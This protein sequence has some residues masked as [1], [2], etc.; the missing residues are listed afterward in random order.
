LGAWDVGIIPTDKPGLPQQSYEFDAAVRRS[1]QMR[2]DYQQALV[3]LDTLRVNMRLSRDQVRPQLDLGAQFGFLGDSQTGLAVD[4]NGQ[5]IT[6]GQG[7][8]FGS[9]LE[10]LLSFDNFQWQVGFVLRQPLGN[11]A[12]LSRYRVDK[13]EIERALL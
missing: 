9:N 13:F 10:S 2:P 8:I 7:D 5:L 1:L 12:A 3:N 6:T 4:P 11:R